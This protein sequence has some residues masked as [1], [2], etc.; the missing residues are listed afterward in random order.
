MR[1]FSGVHSPWIRVPFCVVYATDTPRTP[2]FQSTF[3]SFQSASCTSERSS[4]GGSR[5]WMDSWFSVEEAPGVEAVLGWTHGFLSRKLLGW[6]PCLDGLMVF[7]RGSSWGGSRAWMDS[8]FSV[9]EAPGV[10]AVLGWTHGFLSRKLLGWKPCLDGLMVFCRGSSWGGSRAWMDSWFS[11]EEAPGVEAV[12]GWTHG[13]LSRKLLGWKPCL[14]GL[15]VFCRGSSWGGSRA[16]MDSWFSVEEAPG[17]EAVL[18]WT[19]GFLSRKLL[20][21]KPC[22]DGLMVFCRGSG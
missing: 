14:D 12:L 18:G 15:M 22:L 9:E 6:K 11:V 2:P 16:W 10:E 7:C 17:V 20:G 21:W 1:I 3:P 19:H 13:F 8:W 4:W 5:A